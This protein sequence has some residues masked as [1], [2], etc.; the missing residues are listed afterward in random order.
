MIVIPEE[1]PDLNEPPY[2]GTFQQ[3]LSANLGKLVRIDFL[4]GGERVVTQ[5]GI[6]DAVGVQ[7][8]VLYQ[9]DT[10]TFV[11]GDVFGIKFV[12]FLP[13]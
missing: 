5:S 3:L 12:T 2:R 7:Y 6:V 4:V 8:V 1:I 11:S 10:K 9:P 13:E